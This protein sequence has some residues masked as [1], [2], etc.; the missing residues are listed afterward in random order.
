MQHISHPQPDSTMRRLGRSVAGLLAAGLVAASGAFASTAHGQA[1]ANA[2]AE[3]PAYLRDNI[4]VV[5]DGS[6]S[7]NESYGRTGA[8]KMAVAKEA[9]TRVL[10][11]LPPSI[12]LGVVAFASNT[13]DPW[14]VPLGPVDRDAVSD[15]INGVVAGGKTPL[16]RHLKIAADRL[17]AQRAE[18]RGYGTYRLLVVTDGK[19]SDGPV[20]RR[21]L[22]LVLSRGIV[23]D[24][25]GV[26]MA[27]ELDLAQQVHSYR[28]A[29]DPDA[30]VRSLAEVTA[31]IGA[32]RSDGTVDESDF[33]LL[34]G[35]S[36]QAGAVLLGALVEPGDMPIGEE[37]ASGPAGQSADRQSASRPATSRPSTT[38]SAPTSSGSTGST[39]S[40]GAIPPG[41]GTSS[42]LSLFGLGCVVVVFAFVVVIFIIARILK[43]L[44]SAGRG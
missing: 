39:G 1:S 8:I 19:A 25:I 36:D 28:R 13:N 7:M 3:T 42:G 29:D 44:I 17:L 33:E 21:H 15:A 30:L 35:M 16:G 2:A 41:S 5:F 18:Q 31:E 10:G 24:V 12:N 34:A 23:M 11:E 38:F 6:G 14:V 20:L 40:T 4:V 22:P 37:V 27:E 9:L 32:I 26:D 43:A